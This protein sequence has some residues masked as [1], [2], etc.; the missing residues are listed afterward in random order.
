MPKRLNMVLSVIENYI[1]IFSEI[2]ILK[3]IK[4][5]V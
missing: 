4:I 5:G 1:D 2:L 3:A